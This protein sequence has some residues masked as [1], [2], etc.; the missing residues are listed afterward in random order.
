MAGP[1]QTRIIRRG[2]C[3]RQTT[4]AYLADVFP[5]RHGNAGPRAA[6]AKAGTRR[7]KYGPDCLIIPGVAHHCGARRASQ[8]GPSLAARAA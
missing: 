3:Q 7:S 5:V 2:A 1:E 8:P 6:A 4:A